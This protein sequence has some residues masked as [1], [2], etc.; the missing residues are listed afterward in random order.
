MRTKVMPVRAPTR[1]SRTGAPT[2]GSRNR[3][4]VAVG[5]RVRGDGSARFRRV[6]HGGSR[7]LGLG[8]RRAVG[9]RDV[10]RV[11]GL[12]ARLGRRGLDGR[13]RLLR[14]GGA[15]SRRPVGRRWRRRLTLLLPT[16]RGGSRRLGRRRRA[17][18]RR[19]GRRRAG[20]GGG[21]ALRRVER[22]VALLLLDVV[23]LL[24]VPVHQATDVNQD[25]R[26]TLRRDTGARR[27]GGH[28][29][30]DP[31]VLEVAH[32][33]ILRHHHSL[34]IGQHDPLRHVAE[35]DVRAADLRDGARDRVAH[36]DDGARLDRLDAGRQLAQAVAHLLANLVPVRAVTNEPL[37][38]VVDLVLVAVLGDD[39]Q[40]ERLVGR[41]HPVHNL[42]HVDE[43]SL[44][45][46]RGQVLHALVLQLGQDG[47]LRTVGVGAGLGVHGPVG[48]E[49]LDAGCG[50]GG[51]RRRSRAG[52]RGRRSGCR[53]AGAGGRSGLLG[54]LALRGP[55]PV[56]AGGHGVSGALGIGC[57]GQQAFGVAQMVG[58]RQVGALPLV[59]AGETGQHQG[60]GHQ[61]GGDLRRG[62]LH[63]MSPVLP[64][65]RAGAV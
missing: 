28:V 38:Q 11:A 12:V 16:R 20:G 57:H 31:T 43:L 5:V 36:A 9:R 26:L 21:L 45:L 1:Q 2:R 22:Q 25:R 46:V 27:R 41:L 15:G 48:Q 40:V 56:E 14:P 42:A 61:Q 32:E 13:L 64:R 33:A 60:E 55:L 3:S 30:P 49:L 62:R 52:R 6:G 47:R 18:R 7:L 34:G 63:G 29:L 54:L 39:P 17:R 23:H 59:Q 50:R 44:R 37:G 53:S 58:T 19:G 4:A 10:H 65:H 51:A 8:L 35:A 24:P